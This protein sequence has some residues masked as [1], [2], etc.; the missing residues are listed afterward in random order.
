MSSETS[1]V[2]DHAH[3]SCCA[4]PD[5]L[6]AD[7]TPPEGEPLFCV[8]VDACR[9]P[10]REAYI[11]EI[12]QPPVDTPGMAWVTAAVVERMWGTHHKGHAFEATL[13][14]AKAAFLGAEVERLKT[15]R[16]ALRVVAEAARAFV[17][18]CDEDVW[19]GEEDSSACGET[20][21]H[22]SRTNGHQIGYLCDAHAESHRL[23]AVKAASKGHT[24]AVRLDAPEPIETEPR[25]RALAEALAK[26]AKVPT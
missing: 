5:A 8:F 17:P 15:E 26:L 9:V 21:T 25:V 12:P 3:A 2:Q 16:D 18:V 7:Y 13:A 23:A 24:S 6:P 10:I 19:N 22:R 1:T 14:A 11:Y 4:P 20:A